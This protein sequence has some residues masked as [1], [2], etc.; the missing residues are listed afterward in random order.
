MRSSHTG[1]LDSEVFM[2]DHHAYDLQ[3]PFPPVVITEN[4]YRYF[5]IEY[6]SKYVKMY[7]IKTKSDVNKYIDDY[8]K[9]EL[10]IIPAKK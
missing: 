5:I 8:C 3:G 2:G 1:Q 10:A 7:F 6:K 4:F 9:H